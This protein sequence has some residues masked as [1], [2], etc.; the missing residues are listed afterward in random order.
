MS[1]RESEQLTIFDFI[2]DPDEQ[3]EKDC[4]TKS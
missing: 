4:I 2:D 1:N 3:E